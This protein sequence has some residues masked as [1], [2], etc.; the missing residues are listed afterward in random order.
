[1][2]DRKE[3][4]IVLVLRDSSPRDEPTEEQAASSMRKVRSLLKH[5]RREWHYRC[6]SFSIPNAT[7]VMLTPGEGI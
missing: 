4:P 2:S 3:P 7:P 6:E 1:V 5:L